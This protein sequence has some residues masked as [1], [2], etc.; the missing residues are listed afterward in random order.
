MS[1]LK[2]IIDQT[3]SRLGIALTF[4]PEN[5]RDENVPFCDKP[6]EETTDDGTHTFFR[7]SFENAGYYL[8]YGVSMIPCLELQYLAETDYE[9]ATEIYLALSEYE[10]DLT[11]TEVLERAG[12]QNPFDED[13]Q[14]F[15]FEVLLALMQQKQS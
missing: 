12:L 2:K 8:S 4:Y 15:D 13:Y 6:F 1:D 14:V 9:R 10:G 3:A 7:F 11:F 5:E